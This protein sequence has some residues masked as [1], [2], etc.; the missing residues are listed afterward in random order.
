MLLI[1]PIIEVKEN[2]ESKDIEEWK[3]KIK[4]QNWIDELN[5]QH[6]CLQAPNFYEQSLKKLL[7]IQREKI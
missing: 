5:L 1:K 3:I 2:I 7:S 6:S 4:S